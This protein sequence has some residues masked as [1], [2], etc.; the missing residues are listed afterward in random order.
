MKEKYSFA[1]RQ[2]NIPFEIPIGHYTELYNVVRE[3][4]YY[5][6]KPSNRTLMNEIRDIYQSS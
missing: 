6:L 3:E 2:L 5:Y 4:D 1:R